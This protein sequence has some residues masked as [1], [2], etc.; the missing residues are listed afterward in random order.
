MDLETFCDPAA[1]REL[2]QFAQ[3]DVLR[4]AMA[5]LPESQRRVIELLKIEEKTLKEAAVITGMSVAALKTTTHRAIK[6]LRTHL[7]RLEG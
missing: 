7:L 1:N 2:D 4:R 5:E 6:A 3:A